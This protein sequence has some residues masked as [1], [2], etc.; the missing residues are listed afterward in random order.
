MDLLAENLLGYQTI[1]LSELVDK[2][3]QLRDEA[4]EAAAQ[5]D[6]F[7]AAEKKTKKKRKKDDPLDLT[8]IPL[9]ELAQYAAE[10]ADITYQLYELLEP[11]LKES[12]QLPIAQDIEFPLLP[13]LIQ[14]ESQGITLDTEALS[15]IGTDL[16]KTLYHLTADIHREA[17]QEFNLNSPKQLGEILFGEMKLVEKPKKT[18]TGQFKTDEQTLQSLAHEH[19]IVANILTYRE[20]SKLK[21]TYIDA[22]PHHIE[23]HSGR[24]HT[25]F[26]QLVA[27]TGRLASTE[28]NLQNIPIRSDLGKKI[29]AAFVPKEG[30]PSPRTKA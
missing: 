17:G 20:A 9:D 2:H 10:D 25:H 6:L 11:R 28:P 15:T 23:P 13:T 21:S 16:E 24:I 14:I 1:K 18:K 12:G 5:D 8:V 3:E 27:A 29:R 7:A 4:E 26:H 22:L 19:D 30:Q